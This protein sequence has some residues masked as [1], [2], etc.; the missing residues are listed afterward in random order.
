MSGRGCF[1]NFEANYYGTS[2]GDDDNI[3]LGNVTLI[4]G[5]VDCTK[6]GIAISFNVNRGGRAEVMLTLSLEIVGG[7]DDCG[8]PSWR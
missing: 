4:G 7:G 6:K 2:S 8:S 1:T 3:R 5:G